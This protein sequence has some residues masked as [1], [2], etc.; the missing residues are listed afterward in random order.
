MPEAPGPRTR[1][2][3]L[4]LVLAVRGCEK[5][6]DRDK[7]MWDLERPPPGFARDAVELPSLDEFS[8]MLAEQERLAGGTPGQGQRM[9][10][11]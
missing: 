11:R 10:G 3:N 2:A 6:A 7:L 5:Q 4:V 8:S 9:I 1:L